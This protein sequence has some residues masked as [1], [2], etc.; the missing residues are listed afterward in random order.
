MISVERYKE[1]LAFFDEKEIDLPDEIKEKYSDFTE[2][3][4]Q[5]INN[6]LTTEEI[7]ESSDWLTNLI[8][9]EMPQ[10]L[11]EVD[12]ADKIKTQVRFMEHLPITKGKLTIEEKTFFAFANYWITYVMI[13]LDDKGRT[14][15]G[16]FDFDSI[17]HV[18]QIYQEY[19]KDHPE[20]FR[21]DFDNCYE[22]KFGTTKENPI[23]AISV[24]DSYMYLRNLCRNN[25]PVNYERIGS[26]SGVHNNIIDKYKITYIE[27][28]DSG[29][30][31]KND[32]IY[33]DPYSEETS[34]APPEGYTFFSFKT[35]SAEMVRWE[36][37][38]RMIPSLFYDDEM[39]PQFIDRISPEKG[40]AFERM[41]ML[42]QIRKV[43]NPYKSGSVTAESYDVEDDY[44]V[45]LIEMPNPEKHPL[46][47]HLVMFY[48][49]DFSEKYYYTLGLSPFDNKQI[50]I[51]EINREL[52]VKV[53]GS[54]KKDI[55]ETLWNIFDGIKK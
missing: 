27:F 1:T 3:V 47:T 52:E 4:G 48:K 9:G 28:E 17:E 6:K 37:E 5:Y 36:Y 40:I 44:S 45:S 23:K 8:H 31:E 30:V 35:N 13:C 7:I 34:L 32:T 19:R 14:V 20:M 54:A 15:S 2:I 11:L 21:M 46:C 50:V 22:Y 29:I 25:L 51:C 18:F 49:N 53:I 33:I 43:E 16:I 26:I 12:K 42:Y 10:L 38:Y 41:E 24:A 55:F 39:Q